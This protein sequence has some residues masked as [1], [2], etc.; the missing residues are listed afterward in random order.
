MNIVSSVVD[1]AKYYAGLG[2]RV[3]VLHSV[4]DGVCSCP[5][6][7]SCPSPGKHPR[8]NDWPSEATVERSV[9]DIL[10]TRW[11]NANLGVRLGPTSRIADV[12][13]DTA[14]GEAIAE[15]LLGDIHTPTYRS[16]RSVHRLFDFPG[17]IA[18]PKAV[19]S[20]GSLEMRFG[21][22]DRGS[23]SVFPPSLHASGKRYE[24]LDELS[25]RD[26]ECQPFPDSL[27]E[28]MASAN[29]NGEM[30]FNMEA[31]YD[32][33]THP[34]ASQGQR[35][36]TLCIA[37]GRYLAEYWPATDIFELAGPLAIAVAH[38]CLVRK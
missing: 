11:P 7:A 13:Y 20:A 21:I 4:T 3:V 8:L 24:W 19:V 6:G 34:G 30:I 1:E 14:K 37:T 16:Q 15:R 36:R 32:L 26:V 23:Q 12:E 29:G 31:D 38:H 35:N 10:W 27:V 25:P 28:L 22:E 33:R 18:I 2:W 17:E 9:I 5:A